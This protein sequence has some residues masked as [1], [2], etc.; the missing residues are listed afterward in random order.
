MGGII[1]AIEAGFPQREIADAAYHYQKQLEKNEK[2][3]VG[4]NK[5]AGSGEK[6]DIPLLKI[7][8]NVAAEQCRALAELRAGRNA[9]EVESC[10][11]A[12]EAAAK[13]TDNLMPHFI[14]AVKAYCTQ[15]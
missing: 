1:P 2:I 6:L 5:Y 4:V 10:L 11:G 14:R 7:G 15:G 9:A 3:V 12:I 13:G 8:E